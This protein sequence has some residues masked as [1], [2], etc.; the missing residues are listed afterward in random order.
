MKKCFSDFCHLYENYLT[1]WLNDSSN[2]H[3]CH[4]AFI[5]VQKGKIS[6]RTTIIYNLSIMLENVIWILLVLYFLC[7]NE[8]VTQ[9]TL[10]P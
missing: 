8:I 4:F 10:H 7:E 1:N 9:V 5:L 2:V 3:L 6:A